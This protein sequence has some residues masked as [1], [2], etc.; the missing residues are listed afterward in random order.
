MSKHHQFKHNIIAMIYDFDGTLTPQPMQE[1]TILPKLGVA[2]QEFWHRVKQEARETGGDEMLTYMRLLVDKLETKQQH[3][4]RSDLCSLGAR[5]KYFP[6]VESWFERIAKYVRKRGGGNI[7]LE[8]Y[9]ISAGQKE[10]LEGVAIR[11]HFT[12]MFASEYFFDH[13]DRATWPNIL[14]NDTIKTQYI[15]RI[16]KGLEAPINEYMPEDQRRIPFSNIVYIGDGMTDVP[17]MTVTKKNGG[18]A[19]AVHRP[20]IPKSIATCRKLLEARRIDFYAPANYSTGRVLEKRVQLI[21]DQ[22][23]AQV[24]YQ[25]EIFSARLSLG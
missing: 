9:I 13:H 6:G 2:P 10:I 17:G 22:I 14:I 15:F 3:L 23:I 1:Y 7:R 19:I 16:N 18:Y 11:E 25:R 21:L 12:A 24:L 4:N 20:R 8:N 5:I